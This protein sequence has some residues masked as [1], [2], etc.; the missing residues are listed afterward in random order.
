MKK[1]I[2]EIVEA[3][4]RGEDPAAVAGPPTR[5]RSQPAPEHAMTLYRRMPDGTREEIPQTPIG[6]LARSLTVARDKAGLTLEAC[7]VQFGVSR[8]YLC[9]IEKGRRI[10]T[11]ARAWEWAKVLGEA[12]EHWAELAL[13]DQ[14]DREGLKGLRIKIEVA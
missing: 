9:D 14:I 5:I 11:V 10:L 7:A 1:S 4:E 2:Q 3:E 6:L 12:P 8:Q 13:Q